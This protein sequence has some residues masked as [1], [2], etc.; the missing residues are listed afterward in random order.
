M[1]R[2]PA[3]S[4]AAAESKLCLKGDN[5]GQSA[6]ASD[7]RL[8]F[9]PHVLPHDATSLRRS[10]GLPGES[11]AA[12]LRPLSSSAVRRMVALVSALRPDSCVV[13]EVRPSPNHGERKLCT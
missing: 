13:A 2:A 11:F 10:G 3:R 5:P 7:S 4:G 8:Y 9:P 1:K 12:V 6:T